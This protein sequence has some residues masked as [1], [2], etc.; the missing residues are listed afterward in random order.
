MLNIEVNQS[1]LL[2]DKEAT[3][4]LGLADGTLSVWRSKGRYSIP[5]IK[6]GA[7]VRYRKSDLDAWIESRIQTATAK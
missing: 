4:H 3:K 6:I 2:S 5:F 1:E 7:N